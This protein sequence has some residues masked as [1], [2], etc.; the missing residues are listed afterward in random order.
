MNIKINIYNTNGQLLEV[1]TN[2]MHQPG[3]YNI[4]WNA[5]GYSSG[6]YFVKL[7]SKDFV[8]TQ[9]IMLIK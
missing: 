7:I 1:L 3:I 9:K 8:D 4:N 6:V 2:K 5:K